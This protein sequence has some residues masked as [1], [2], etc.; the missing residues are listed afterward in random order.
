MSDLALTG[1][2]GEAFQVLMLSETV[3]THQ[4]L[5][6]TATSGYTQ[7]L[8]ANT[9]IV[10]LFATQDC[11]VRLVRSSSSSVAVP[12]VSG[13]KGPCVFVAGGVN[14]FFGI[15]KIENVLWKLAVVRD[16]ASG[17]IHVTEGA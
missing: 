16:S 9:T 11:W 17:T 15:P 8:R 6:F 1:N 4:P 13:A 5:A 10:E 3:D 7:N 2:K 14:K 12:G